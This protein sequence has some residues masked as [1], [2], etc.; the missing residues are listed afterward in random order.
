MS[1][2]QPLADE[3]GDTLGFYPSY[4]EAIDEYEAY[5][6]LAWDGSRQV[7]EADWSERAGHRVA[8]SIDRL[9]DAST[10][11]NG[12][13]GSRGP[14]SDSGAPPGSTTRPADSPV[15]SAVEFFSFVVFELGLSIAA[16]RYAI[17]GRQTRAVHAAT[18]DHQQDGRFDGDHE[19][20][21]ALPNPVRSGLATSIPATPDVD[22]VQPEDAD[23]EVA[24]LYDRALGELETPNVNNVFRALAVDPAFLRAVVD[25]QGRLLEDL[26]SRWRF[27]RRIRDLY[28][29]VLSANAATASHRVALRNLGYERDSIDEVAGRI[30]AFHENVPTLAVTVL[31]AARLLER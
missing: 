12:L 2:N 16:C 3:I 22:L 8:A 25:V 30:R 28:A 14:G 31:V 10:G 5:E 9:L 15:R 1:E 4:F 13:L 23:E 11:A 17:D 26:P 20:R 19:G 18:A 7:L 6:R 24:A 29:A 27:E 21:E